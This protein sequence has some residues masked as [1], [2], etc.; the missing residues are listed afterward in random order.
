MPS[1]RRRRP[2]V[3]SLGVLRQ[4]ARRFCPPYEVKDEAKSAL[5]IT[6]VDPTRQRPDLSLR[7]RYV[8]RLFFKANYLVAESRIPGDGPAEDGQLSFRFRGPLSR[9]RSSVRW[10]NP[11]EGGERWTERLEAPL[12]DRV[13]AIQ[14]VESLHIAWRARQRSWHLYLETLS[15]SMVGGFMTAMPIAV[16]IDPGEVKAIIGL[17][18]ILAETKA[19]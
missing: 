5:R 18:E 14:A 9:Q 11:V 16:P 15:G 8:R 12:L 3:S 6:L 7:H 1:G 10:K 17:I 2:Q 19:D 13:G 4:A